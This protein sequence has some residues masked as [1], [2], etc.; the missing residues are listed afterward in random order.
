MKRL[1]FVNKNTLEV[2]THEEMMEY[3]N[4]KAVEREDNDELFS[5]WLEKQGYTLV[6]SFGWTYDD[7]ADILARWAGHCRAK[8]TWNVLENWKQHWLELGE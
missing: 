6:Q 3:V 5:A 2:V 4:M 1:V 7:R 8:E